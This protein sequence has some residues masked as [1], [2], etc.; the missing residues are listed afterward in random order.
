MFR[1]P[2]AALS[3]V[4]LLA[5]AV[6]AAATPVT[7]NQ[8]G[9]NVFNDYGRTTVATSPG[10]GSIA[11][12]FDVTASAAIPG[13]GTRFSAWCLDIGRRLQLGTRYDV[14]SDPFNADDLTQS[15][16]DN[17]QRLFNF[18]FARAT[19][20]D[21]LRTGSG[22]AAGANANSAGFQLALWEVVNEGAANAFNLVSGAFKVTSTTQVSNDAV[23]VATQLLA[24][25]ATYDLD[26]A[27]FRVVYLE[28]QNDNKTDGY[29]RDSQNLA[30]LAPVPVP[31][32]GALLLAALAGL[33]LARR[34]TVRNT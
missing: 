4:I 15:Q 27:W 25:M 18:A 11:G 16:M 20:L 33:G 2:A 3:C 1:R 29:N 24:G 32:A 14:T 9:S 34:R 23:T 31:A 30:A 22:T 8:T 19:P 5:L 26:K 28:S 10:G 6:P 12:A 17:I 21:I 13:L 7:L